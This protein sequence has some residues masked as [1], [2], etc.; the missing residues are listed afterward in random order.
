M[1]QFNFSV[2]R[3]TIFRIAFTAV[4]N[5]ALC[6]AGISQNSTYSLTK[7]KVYVQ[8]SHVFFKQGETVFF[9]LY[10]VNAADQTP[11]KLSNTVYVEVINPAGNVLKQLN[12]RVENGYAEG[13]Y[14]FEEQAPGGIYKLRAYTTWMRNEKEATYFIKELTLQKFIAPRVLMK[15]N[16]PEKGYGAGS[17]VNADFSMRNLNDLPIKF[18]PVNFAVSLNGKT[19]QTG[20]FISDKDGKAKIKFQLPAELNSNDGLLNV[21]VNYD[22]Y[23]ESISRSIPIVL[24]KI[25]LQFMPEG[26]TLVEGISTNI[27]FKAVNENGK[28]ADIKG[29]LVD[30]KGNRL[31][32][33][34]SYHFG[35]GKFAFTPVKGEHYK[36]KIISPANIT[37]D[38]ELPAASENGVVMNLSKQKGN[39]H[40]L[41]KSS[42]ERPVKLIASTKSS[43]FYNKSLLLLRGENDFT[44]DEELFPVGI[45]R[46][47]LLTANDLPLAERIMFL[48]E[49]KN[50]Q[51]SITSDKRKYLPRE[52]VS[53]N[54]KTVDEKGRPVPADLSLAVVDDKLWSFADDKQDHILSWMLM[55]SELQ[56]KIEEPQFYFK[57]DEPKSIPALDLV[58]LTSGYRYFDYIDYV[59]EQGQLKFTPD[60]DNI[61]SG[62]VVDID[63]KPVRA[64]VFLAG[65]TAGSKGMQME[66][67]D[68][69]TFYFSHL[70][71]GM[72]Y[73]VIAGS[74]RKEKNISIKILQNGTG[75]NPLK[76]SQIKKVNIPEQEF[77]AIGKEPIIKR[78]IID[79]EFP[80]M[81][82]HRKGESALTE[83]VVTGYGAMRKKDLT[84]SIAIVSGKD[85]TMA[86]NFGI[87]LQGKV[88][89]IMV[90]NNANPGEDPKVR[91]RGLGS[92]SRTD[93]PIYIINGVVVET[94]DL[95]SL[96]PNEIASVT[97]WKDAAAIA[98]YGAKAVNGVV[99]IESKKFNREKIR[100]NFATR[101]KF[102]SQ[103]IV[104]SNPSFTIARR[105]Y[106][107]AYT[108]IKPEERT[109][110]RETIYWNPVIQTDKNGNATVEFYNSDATTTFRAI[111][112]GIG[113]NG[114]LGRAEATYSAQ[115]SMSVDAKIPPYLTV[116]DKA[117]IPLVI[118]NNRDEDL[119]IS[120]SVKVPSQ[121]ETGDYN[122]RLTLAPDS[123]RQVLIPLEALGE[124]K[125]NIHFI[126]QNKLGSESISL[127]ITATGKGFQVFATVSGSKTQQHRFAINKL[128]PG[129]L[130]ANL[131]VF[132]DVEGQLLDGIESM[133]REP[134]GCFEQTS[135]CTYPNVYV[136][137]YLKES[138]K[139]RPEIEEKAMGYIKRGY[140]R[141][142]GYETAQN[143][144]EWFGHAP[145][146][147]ALTAYGL[148]EFT[149]MREFVKVDEQMLKRTKDYLMSRR[150]GQGSFK[151]ASGGYDR[152]A[153]VP[154]KIANVYIVYALTQAG[155]GQEIQPE[156][157]VAVKKALE[158][159]DAY[160]MSMMALAA[161]SMK[162]EIDYV[163]LMTALKEVFKSKNLFAETSV[164]NSR[165]ASLRVETAS[166]YALALMRE[167][168]PDLAYI[169]ELIRRVLAEKSYYGYGSTQATVLALKSIVEYSKLTGRISAN[170]QIGFV[171]NDKKIKED[172]QFVNSLKE[173]ENNFGVTFSDNAST[174]PYSLEV[175]YNTFTP[176]ND[177]KA[178]LQISTGLQA[179][180]VHIGET[181]RMEVAVTNT[182]DILQPMAIAKIG[183]PAGLS[184]QPWQLK[185]I[186]EKNSVAYYEIFDNYLVLY[187]M[188]FDKRETKKINL[189]LKADVP[190][191][192]K[193]KASTVY[194]YY[195]PEYKNWNEGT[196]IDI[197]P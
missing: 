124:A 92:L 14:D 157:R 11:A 121:F 90:V 171:V 100:F 160:L 49:D 81:Q 12:Y 155:I 71:S 164:V 152:F 45:A 190:G 88:A 3:L 97:I 131:K 68:D 161:N 170:S 101:Y 96:N 193:A 195:T 184:T 89:G 52:K 76:V 143:G 126:V 55:S 39:I 110:F 38:Y 188:G 137:K 103:Y 115:N 136:L 33:F 77:V 159:N 104:A 167:S 146:H 67:D 133:L 123:S 84:G 24:N 156:Y 23:T 5:C 74:L 165:D 174:I 149:D 98:I 54:I 87:A 192:Y 27:A 2:M 154:N 53:L 140:E 109:D 187:W 180:T 185:E 135:S 44:I 128:V 130:K 99:V 173:G 60:Q 69:G 142:V 29:E 28:A 79:K 43:E 40:V 186:M 151:L 73:Y 194:L 10:V 65:T 105:F 182:K 175:S 153:A 75:Y 59:F 108:G 7:E 107:P 132:K 36:V 139:S 6:L 166:L 20:K 64:S 177:A 22:S 61:L 191:Q 196:E 34:E 144:F 197:Q 30:S 25:G 168:S 120:I 150:D 50:L 57:K 114:K 9:K 129:T 37:S 112:E 117:L 94:P 138:G 31:L 8:T 148:L 147:E 35:M 176:P 16:F 41:L 158:S 183:I 179:R 141:L 46:F 85:I 127:P 80:G 48:N 62:V 19:V 18:F 83:V 66:T 4:L 116:G 51:V 178:E 95:R 15:L 113:W 145:A 122:K 42:S 86:N 119:D 93:Q 106:A 169:G 56:G 111:A 118:K 17:E 134:Y 63:G 82:E 13:S 32:S 72:N 26:G 47:T 181:I 162:N 102:A 21:T 189:D 172:D 91:I 70:E 163:Q 78:Q 58:M 125:G 1:Y